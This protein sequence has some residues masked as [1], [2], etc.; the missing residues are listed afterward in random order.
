MILVLSLCVS[1]W[2]TYM[3]CLF[4]SGCM[5]SRFFR[6]WD[7]FIFCFFNWRF[8]CSGLLS[9]CITQ[10]CTLTTIIMVSME[11]IHPGCK[12]E[13]RFYTQTPTSKLSFTNMQWHLQILVTFSAKPDAGLRQSG[14]GMAHAERSD[15]RL[16]D[17]NYWIGYTYNCMM[18]VFRQQYTVSL[19]INRSRSTDFSHIP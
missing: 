6:V 17:L 18:P 11:W 9:S 8:N 4:H 16:C 1:I 13:Q 12:V 2:Y 7:I 10:R 15:N 3:V 5:S 19:Y 14:S